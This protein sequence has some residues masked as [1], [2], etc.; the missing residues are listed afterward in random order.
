M[1]VV[2]TCEELAFPVPEQQAAWRD[3][4]KAAAAKKVSVLATGVNPGYAMDALA[5]MLTAPCAEVYAGVRHPRGGRAHA[6][7]APAAQGG[8]GAEPQPVPRAP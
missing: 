5:L 6:P 4:D 8:R 1:H 3:I 2:T 7:P